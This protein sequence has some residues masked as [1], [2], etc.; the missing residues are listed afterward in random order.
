MPRY[1]YEC[2]ACR[3][4][5]EITHGMFFVL[6]RCKLCHSHETVYLLPEFNI[7]KPKKNLEHSNQRPGKIVDQYIKDA[8]EEIKQEKKKR[9]THE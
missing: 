6:D 1:V 7:T 2:T 9:G 5:F 4:T 3:G 8:K